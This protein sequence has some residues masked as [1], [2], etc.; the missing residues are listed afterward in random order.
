MSALRDLR[1][2]EW[3][4][5]P[6]QL[7]SVRFAR[8]GGPGGQ[9]VNKVASK[10]DLRL[11]LEGARAV[12]GDEAVERIREKL[13][14]RLDRDGNLQ[15]ISSEHRDQAKNI[16]AAVERMEL[17]IRGALV[18]PKARRP[19][20]PTRGSKER[21]LEEKRRRGEVKQARREPD[22]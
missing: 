10:V 1:I 17:L 21:R 8:S 7:L 12:L 5:L 18:R 22:R 14:A 3:R 11:D 15:V 6:A 16:E 13:A 4:I 9:N 20:R 2:T 19:T